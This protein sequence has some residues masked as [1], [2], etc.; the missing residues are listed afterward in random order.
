MGAIL[1]IQ[2]H[3]L[4]AKMKMSYGRTVEELSRM[5]VAD[6]EEILRRD[7]ENLRRFGR[8]ARGGA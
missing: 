4:A 3:P 1:S 5:E 8:G 7:F 2:K 6:M